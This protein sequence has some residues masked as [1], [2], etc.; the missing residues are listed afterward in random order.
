MVSQIDD[1]AQLVEK[2]KMDVLLCVAVVPIYVSILDQ[3]VIFHL[4]VWYTF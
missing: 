1:G 3:F 4:E 2:V